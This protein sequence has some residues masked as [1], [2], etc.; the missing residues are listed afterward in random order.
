MNDSSGPSRCHKR[1]SIVTN[2]VKFLMRFVLF[3]YKMLL[4]FVAWTLTELH[5]T[6][7]TLF[8]SLLL[9]FI[10]I[11]ACQTGTL[12]CHFSKLHRVI[13]GNRKK[14]SAEKYGRETMSYIYK[15]GKNCLYSY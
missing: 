14:L 15:R 11:I 2:S 6:N 9:I 13:S 12:G 1:N 3:R 5:A 8:F 7:P 4:F 10:L